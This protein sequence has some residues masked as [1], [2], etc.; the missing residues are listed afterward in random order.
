VW[1]SERHKRSSLKRKG[2]HCAIGTSDKLAKVLPD[3]LRPRSGIDASI[4]E[5]R[6]IFRISLSSGTS[7][8]AMCNKLKHFT[9]LYLLMSISSYQK[10]RRIRESD[11]QWRTGCANMG[12]AFP[13]SHAN[14]LCGKTFAMG[15]VIFCR[16]TKRKSQLW[17]RF[18]MGKGRPQK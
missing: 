7:H 4:T 2:Q 13:C 18:E 17:R 3:G 10:S 12:Q 14:L 1:L 5:K 8:F 16:T 15:P 6:R 9:V 11:Q